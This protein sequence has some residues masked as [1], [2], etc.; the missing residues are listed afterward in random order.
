MPETSRAQCPGCAASI[1]DDGYS[2]VLTCAY[3]GTRVT[4]HRDRA[5]TPPAPQPRPRTERDL[6]LERLANEE[7]DWDVRIRAAERLGGADVLLPLFA[8]AM[9]MIPMFLV[10]ANSDDPAFRQKWEPLAGCAFWTLGPLAAIVVH[11][12]RARVRMKR[13]QVIAGHRD[14]ALAP[15][16]AR[17][18]ELQRP[19]PL[20]EKQRR[21]QTLQ[22][23]QQ[24][25]RRRL[26]RAYLL[27]EE[28]RTSGKADFFVVPVLGCGIWFLFSAITLTILTNGWTEEIS[29]LGAMTFFLSPF[30]ILLF[31]VI[32]PLILRPLRR[33]ARVRRLEA[34]RDE[35]APKLQA[36]LNE[37]ESEL[38]RLT[39]S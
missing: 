37:I 8:A 25:T 24:E 32:V 14:E 35:I 6:L 19:A 27:P 17:L 21:M 5:H 16:R 18:A 30:A 11:R 31:G 7:R 29:E 1:A 23:E 33:R 39:R 13:A 28:V 12:L 10:V 9:A 26:D 36:R 20:T 34:E 3:C 22:Y 38:A 4:V 2:A 15:L